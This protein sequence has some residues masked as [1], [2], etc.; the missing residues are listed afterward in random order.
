MTNFE[1]CRKIYERFLLEFP[2]KPGVWINFAEMEFKLEE[3]KRARLLYESAIVLP[4]LNMPETVWKAYIDMEIRLSEFTN[5]RELFRR[6][7]R[8][9][10]HVKVWISFA[11]FEKERD[12]IIEMR[13]LFSE[14]DEFFKSKDDLKEQRKILVETWLSIEQEI[15]D[16]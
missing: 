12:Q 9:T 13:R 10:K 16:E 1:R 4:A 8:K 5:A 2:D 7:L 14:A 11:Q 3:Y 15:G 6:L